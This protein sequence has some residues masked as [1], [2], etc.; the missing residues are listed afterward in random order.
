MKIEYCVIGW[1]TLIVVSMSWGYGEKFNKNKFSGIVWFQTMKML[2]ALLVSPIT[3]FIVFL[4][5]SLQKKHLHK[6][7]SCLL[8]CKN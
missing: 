6:N 5:N 3:I 4:L 1:L 2:V 8:N 7:W